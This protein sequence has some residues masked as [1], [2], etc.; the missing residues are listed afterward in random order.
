MN[1]IE[2]Y[3]LLAHCWAQVLGLGH[4]VTCVLLTNVYWYIFLRGCHMRD[5]RGGKSPFIES[6][7]I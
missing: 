1:K 3:A 7:G 2:I 6:E 5:P 4:C